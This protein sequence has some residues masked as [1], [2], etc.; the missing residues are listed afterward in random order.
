MKRHSKPH[1][2][3]GIMIELAGPDGCGKTTNL[4]AL[5]QLFEAIDIPVMTTREPGG[6][7][8]AERIRDLVLHHADVEEPMQSVTELLLFGAA[9][10]QH[11][12][13]K[14]YPA[15]NEGVV[16]ISD[17]FAMSTRAYQGHGR[18]RLSEVEKLESLTHPGFSPDYI[19][20][21]DI[22]FELCLERARARNST[23]VTGDRFE[24]ADLEL[25]RRIY[26]GFKIEINSL[27]ARYPNRVVIIDATKS[28]E[29][30]R[31][32]LKEFVDHVVKAHNLI[33]ES[34]PQADLGF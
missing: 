2:Y 11:L 15:L 30:I 14:V 34:S 25:K 13:E 6:T 16:V 3:Q 5:R 26:E 32:A 12:L 10:V 17:R 27:S 8:L 21:F 4:F 19:V 18:G 22:P 9:R 7:P 28:L 1:H 20:Y 24:D 31:V 23:P 33:K 29:E